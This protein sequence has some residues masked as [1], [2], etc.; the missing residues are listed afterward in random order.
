MAL[1]PT[2]VFIILYCEQPELMKPMLV[3]RLGWITIGV[4]TIM[5]ALGY[6]VIKKI[7]TIDI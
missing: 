7:V 2:A 1:A 6:Y 4:I 3:T 5:E